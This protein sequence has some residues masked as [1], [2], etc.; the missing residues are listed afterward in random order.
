M[1]VGLAHISHSD[2]ISPCTL[3]PSGR[4]LCEAMRRVGGAPAPLIQQILRY[5]AT[6]V[7]ELLHDGFVQPE[8]HRRGSVQRA[9]ISQVRR[10][11]LA[12]G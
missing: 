6:V 11:F 8:I 1:A 7:R 3:M 4:R 12:V 2:R 10:E 9:G 5:F